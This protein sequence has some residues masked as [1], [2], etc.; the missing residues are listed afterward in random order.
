M[1]TLNVPAYGLVEPLN[2]AKTAS[3]NINAGIGNLTIDRLPGSE[4]LL[5]SGTLQYHE[6][7]GVPERFAAVDDGHANLTVRSADVKRSGFRWPWEACAGG[8]YEWQIHLNANV[9]A[10]I[11]ARTGGGNVRLDLTGMAVT[12]VTA[13]SGGG[14]MDVVLPDNASNLAVDVRTGGG[15]VT[16]VVGSGTTG[17]N[18][19]NAG[20]GAG[21]VVVSVP[22]G[23]AARIHAGS[24]WGKVVV[25]PRFEQVDGKTYQSPEYD[26]APNRIEIEVHSGAGN[27]SVSST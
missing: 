21:N 4:Q 19:V 5:A 18:T 3:V 11:T 26:A 16:V 24:G 8:A 12:R 27:V 22:R 13:D 23:L 15:S 7:Q 6:N 14:N 9:P 17:S 2:G 10:D 20:S 25:D 1:K